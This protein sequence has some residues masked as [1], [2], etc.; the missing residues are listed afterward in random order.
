ML[1]ILTRSTSTHGFFIEEEV[2]VIDSYRT[3]IYILRNLYKNIEVR[4][5]T[6][7]FLYIYVQKLLAKS[8]IFAH[9]SSRLSSEWS[10]NFILQFSVNLTVLIWM[11]IALWS[12][13]S[14]S[15]TPAY[16]S[17]NIFLQIWSKHH[18]NIYTSHLSHG[19]EHHGIN[20][21]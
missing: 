9:K 2:K 18:R 7:M 16:I 19:N 14:D 21:K 3:W 6:K 10:L 4:I 12:V 20:H 5:S 17:L 1:R 8:D 11:N 15:K 13:I